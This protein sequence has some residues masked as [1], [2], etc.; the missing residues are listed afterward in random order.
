LPLSPRGGAEA[1]DILASPLVANLQRELGR[2]SLEFKLS[3]ICQSRDGRGGLPR[4]LRRQAARDVRDGR[5]LYRQDA[6]G[7]QPGHD[8]GTAAERDRAGDHTIGIEI[9]F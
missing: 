2:L 3:A 8:R 4:Q 9:Q 1:L 5:R 6:E 7:R